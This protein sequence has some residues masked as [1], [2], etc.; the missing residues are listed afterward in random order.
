MLQAM[1]FLRGVLGYDSPSRA[2]APQADMAPPIPEP[3]TWLLMLLGVA[4]VALVARR[5]KNRQRQRA[6]NGAMTTIGEFI[7]PL[8]AGRPSRKVRAWLPARTN[9]LVWALVQKWRHGGYIISRRSLI[10]WRITAT[11]RDRAPFWDHYMWSPDGT[12]WYEWTHADKPPHLLLRELPRLLSFPG[13]VE[14]I[15]RLDK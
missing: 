2:V 12:L 1:G 9:C 13:Q 4:L 8:I 10:K 6:V 15:I 5:H 7:D 3:S 11:G 14:L